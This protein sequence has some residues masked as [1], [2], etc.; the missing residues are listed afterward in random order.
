MRRSLCELLPFSFLS[1]SAAALFFI[2]ESVLDP[3]PEFEAEL[4]LM[5][6]SGPSEIEGEVFGR[7]ELSL[8]LRDPSE[9]F[10]PVRRREGTETG[11]GLA[12]AK[13]CRFC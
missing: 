13:A 9:A 8:G 6:A 12:E 1:V 10:D 4:E 2:A 11:V 7:M 3:S 5:E